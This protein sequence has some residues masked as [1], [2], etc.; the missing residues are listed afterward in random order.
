MP[1]ISTNLNQYISSPN[2]EPLAKKTFSRDIKHR[3]NKQ[4]ESSSF[5]K[6]GNARS[7]MSKVLDSNPE[8]GKNALSFLCG[9]ASKITGAAA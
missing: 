3:E 8:A 5:D 4:P 9:C 2:R 6:I 7:A 1:G